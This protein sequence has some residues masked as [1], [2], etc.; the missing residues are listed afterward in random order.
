MEAPGGN[1][2]LC[3]C[4]GGCGPQARAVEGELDQCIQVFS[5]M[6]AS[7]EAPLGTMDE[8]AVHRC[9]SQLSHTALSALRR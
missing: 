4:V 5:N 9:A 8:G 2:T 3:G 1:V 7:V 6:S